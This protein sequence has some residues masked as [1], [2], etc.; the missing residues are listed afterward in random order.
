VNT[1]AET[2]ARPRKA[3]H[4]TRE[5]RVARGKAARAQVPLEAHA[6]VVLDGRPD[7]VALLESQAASRVAELVP[8]RYGRMST[9]AFAFYRGAALVMATDLQAGESSGLKVQLCG[10]AHMSNFGVFGSPERHLLF[11]INDFDETAPGSFEWDVKRL[12]ASLEIAGRTNGFKRK[13][14]RA[15]VL[16][17][18][19]NYRGAMRSFAESGNLDVWYAR[20][21]IDQAFKDIRGMLTL[22]GARRTEAA[23]TKARTRDS[24]TA[25]SK[26]T[27]QVDGHPRI[28]GEPP[29]I[30]TIET[31][32]P[33]RDREDVMHEMRVLVR[34]YRSSLPSD[35]RHLIEDYQL[36]DMARKVVGVGSVGTRCWILLMQGVDG[37]DPLFLQAK[38]AGPSVIELVTGSVRRGQSGQRVVQGQRLMQAAS[39]I[40]LGYQRVTGVDDVERDYYLRQLRDWKM[41]LPPELME[42]AGMTVYGR[43]CGWTLARA[44]ARSGDRVAIAAYLGRKDAFDNAIADYAATYADQ[45]E[46]DHAALVEAIS[47]GRVQAVTGL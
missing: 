12:A 34:S 45:N 21:D 35:R 16:S 11:D 3:A 44:H 46:S 24:M 29:L 10:D 9:S 18:V 39:D 47:S 43:M 31:L 23:I 17:A 33:G 14:R 28:V 13:V 6:S 15:I 2:E 42:V 22:E 32:F 38:E 36:V 8:I 40:F 7:P 27:T 20:L 1:A 19:E 4:P 25:L 26:L 30:E 41:S 37:S 5:E